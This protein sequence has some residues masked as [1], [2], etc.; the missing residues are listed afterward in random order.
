[1]TLFLIRHAHAADRHGWDGDDR[2]RPLS[3]KGRRQARA[4][5]ED[6]GRRDLERVLSSP[7]LRCT[8]TVEPLAE[9]VGCEV[10][11][12]PEL[13]EGSDPTAVIRL[14]EA[15]SAGNVAVCTHGDLVPEVVELLHRRGMEILGETGNR[16]G[17]WWEI[18]PG[19][20]G[21]RSATHHPPG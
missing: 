18:E 15:N 9:T 1:M 8:E 19:P 16:K 13:L 11:V 4:L 21:F 14:L 3:P 5:V 2:L 12:V 7:A 6:V 20:D 17:S 10:E